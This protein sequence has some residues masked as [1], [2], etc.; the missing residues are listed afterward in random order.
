MRS[1]LAVRPVGAEAREVVDAQLPPDVLLG[2]PGTQGA[3]A[4]VVVGAGWESAEGVNVQVE[5][6]IAV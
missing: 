3:E 5:T 4:H 2:A 6:L 1:D